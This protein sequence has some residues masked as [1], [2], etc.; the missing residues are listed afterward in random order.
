[1]KIRRH[2]G[3]TF[4]VT[5]IRDVRQLT[6]DVFAYTVTENYVLRTRTSPTASRSPP[7]PLPPAHI[8]AVC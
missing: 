3:Q 5:T 2:F 7:S 1:M 6:P 8:I 4:M